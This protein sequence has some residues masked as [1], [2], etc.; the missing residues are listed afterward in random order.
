MTTV[1]VAD[2]GHC[3]TCSG[4]CVELREV[5]ATL[6]NGKASKNYVDG[7]MDKFESKLDKQRGILIG[8]LVSMALVFLGLA[9]NLIVQIANM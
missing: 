6:T 1:S 8:L 7:K 2:N 5:C 9:G 4:G 3:R